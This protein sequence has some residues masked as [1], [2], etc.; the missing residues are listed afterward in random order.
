MPYRSGSTATILR[1]L[2]ACAGC[3]P[4]PLLLG[5]LLTAGSFLVGAAPSAAQLESGRPN[6]FFDCEGRDCNSQYYRTEIGWVNW[7]NDQEVSDVHVI[8]TSTSTGVG[9]REYRLD[10]LGREELLAYEDQILWQSLP[11]D[12]DRERLDG[13]T[14]VLGLGIARFATVA[15]YRDLVALRGPDPESSVGGRRVVSQAEVDDPWNLWVFRLNGNANLDGEELSSTRRFNGGVN[16]SRVTPL[17]KINFNSNVNYQRREVE[18]EDGTFTDTRVDWNVS[19]L[20]VYSLADHWSVG[21]QGQA[22][23][24]TRVN[25]DFRWE[26]TPAIEYSVFPYDEATRRAFTFGYKVGP[27]YRDYIEETVFGETSE[28]RFEQ[29][30]E[31]ELSQRQTWGDAGLTLRGSHYLHDFGLYNVSLRGNI[32]FRITR[33]LSVNARGDVGWV[34]DQIY[35]SA[36]GAT[37]EEAL[38][39][40]RQRGT[41]FN[42][43][44]S[45][46]FSFQFGS[47]FN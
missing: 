26:V 6:V 35:L 22:A 31:V 3:A 25:Q 11:T 16:A 45:V 2:A 30:L 39:E 44:V 18:L 42:Y 24:M 13:V 47:I 12:T 19:P 32:D 9:G 1:A 20:I 36:A 29:S 4:A 5:V 37:D 10:F 46:G 38:L 8:M 33:G 40:L 15:G 21:L 17:W 7:V 34:E 28:L 41:D 14:H 27:A 43:G 23:R